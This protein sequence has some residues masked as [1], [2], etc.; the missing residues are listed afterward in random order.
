MKDRIVRWEWNGNGLL[1][2]VLC[3]TVI[4]IPVAVVYFIVNLLRIE[5]VVDDAEACADGLRRKT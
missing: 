2:T 4:L 3:L 1:L 5:N